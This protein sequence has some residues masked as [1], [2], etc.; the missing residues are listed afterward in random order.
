MN[1]VKFIAIIITFILIFAPKNIHAQTTAECSFPAGPLVPSQTYTFTAIGLDPGIQYRLQ[2]N[3]QP[4]PSVAADFNGRVSITFNLQAL[5]LGDALQV[6]ISLVRRQATVTANGCTNHVMAVSQTTP[7]AQ[8]QWY[9]CDSGSR[10]CVLAQPFTGTTDQNA[11]NQNCS[12]T[13]TTF[14]P[15]SGGAPTIGC[16]GPNC[17]SA[18]GQSCNTKSDPPGAIVPPGTGDGIM[19]AIGCV[20][21][22]PAAL[23]QGL[24]K[25]AV[26]AGGGIALL[27]MIIGA[28]RMIISVGNPEGVKAGHEQFTS[29]IIGLLFIIFAVFLLKVIGV[30]LLGLPG[31]SP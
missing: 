3:N 12:S 8:Q 14:P 6:N 30:D 21:T 31:F 23:I 27:L 18:A 7:P 11:C 4:T 28:F 29:A 1:S 5:Q 10:S 16:T 9:M 24:L 26:G 25:V 2:I 19:T 13:G 15:G 17:T 20:P 22:Q